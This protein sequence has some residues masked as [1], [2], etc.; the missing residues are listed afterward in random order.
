MLR[1]HPEVVK[2]LFQT[3]EFDDVIIKADAAQARFTQFSTLSPTQ[4][5]EALAAK[6]FRG[7]EGYDE[8]L[9]KRIFIEG[10]YESV[11][12]STPSFCSTH[13]GSTLYGLDCHAT[14][15]QAL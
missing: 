10:L 15:L 5:A 4:Y 14:S 2:Y 6:L 11:C 12:H 13:H 9:L 7:G 1:T 8:Y 3:Y